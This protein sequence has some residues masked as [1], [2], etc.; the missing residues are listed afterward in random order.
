LTTASALA[1]LG[2]LFVAVL[3][4]SPEC[5]AAVRPALANQ[6]QRSINL[7]LGTALST[8]SLTIRQSSSSLLTGRND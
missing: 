6:R 3:I 2:G 7:S 1:A 4:L 8:I 5:L